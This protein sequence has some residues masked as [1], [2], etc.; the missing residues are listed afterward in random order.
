[1]KGRLFTLIMNIIREGLR[2]VSDRD[3]GFINTQTEINSK[4][5]GKM[6]RNLLANINFMMAAYSMANSKR[7]K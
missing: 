5:N 4:E 6:I 2:M 1:M 3:S 7:M